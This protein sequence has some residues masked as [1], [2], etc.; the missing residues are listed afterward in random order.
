MPL[1]SVK[2]AESGAWMARSGGYLRSLGDP[3]PPPAPV[4]PVS[5]TL[6]VLFL[7]DSG[8]LLAMAPKQAAILSDPAIRAYL[9][10]KCPMESGCYGNRCPLNPAAAASTPSF[11]FY[12]SGEDVR[13]MTPVWQ[14]AVAAAKAVNKPLPWLWAWNSAGTEVLSEAWTDPIT[15]LADLQKVGGK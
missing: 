13:Q 11:R 14:Q 6:R 8:G 3:T 2:T 7:Y 15:V 5:S 12:S 4:P 10:D 9:T 1:G